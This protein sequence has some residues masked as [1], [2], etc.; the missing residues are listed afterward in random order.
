MNESSSSLLKSE[1]PHGNSVTNEIIGLR[2]ARRSVEIE[3]FHRSEIL[4]SDWSK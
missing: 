1:W 3:S 4:F 2:S